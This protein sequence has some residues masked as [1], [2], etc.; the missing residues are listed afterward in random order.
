MNGRPRDRRASIPRRRGTFA[1]LLALA[2]LLPRF[3]RAADVSALVAAGDTHYARRAQ[4]ARGGVALPRETDLALQSYRRAFEAAPGDLFVLARLLRALNFRGAFCGAGVEAQRRIFDE[5]R[6]RGQAAVDRLE[7]GVGGRGDEARMAGLRAVPGAPA[8]YYWT[9]ACWGQWALARGRFAA[10][11]AGVAGRVRG[12]AQTVVALDP[13]LEEGGGHH[14]L[15]R[16]HLQSPRIPFLTGWVS[17]AKAVE[18]LRKSY[19]LGPRNPVTWFFLA[20]AILDHEPARAAEARALLRKC[21]DTPP[22]A[23]YHVESLDYAA[24]ARARL[25]EMR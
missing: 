23:D 7:A 14:V 6:R 21:I 25:A 11:R 19:E 4:G 9:A 8:V 12:L 3:A 13:A 16:L 5:G 17:K 2:A 22:R 1:V 24:R 15:G 10:A 20:E 18:H